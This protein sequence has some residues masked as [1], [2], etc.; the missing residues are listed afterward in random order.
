MSDGSETIVE[1]PEEDLREFEY[2]HKSARAYIAKARLWKQEN[3][4]KADFGKVSLIVDFLL[5]E[6]QP[7]HPE[8][9]EMAG[10][11][12]SQFFRTGLGKSKAYKEFCRNFG[13]DTRKPDLAVL[14]NAPVIIAVKTNGDY[15][16]VN[17]VMPDA[18]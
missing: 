3:A 12:I 11:K 10:T 14:E 18:V 2:N 4:E 7:D 6:D 1:I 9:A 8:L 13:I 17:R 5:R 15:V 16:N